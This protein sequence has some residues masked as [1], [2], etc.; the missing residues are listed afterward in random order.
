MD[1][2]ECN[3]YLCKTGAEIIF[4]ATA[5]FSSHQKDARKSNMESCNICCGVS[6]FNVGRYCCPPPEAGKARSELMSRP[7]GLGVSG[8]RNGVVP[9]QHSFSLIWFFS[10]CLGLQQQQ[11][12]QQQQR[13]RQRQQQQQQPK[14]KPR[15][16]QRRP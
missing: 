3:Y 16:G 13:R 10:S 7:M 12:Q 15:P 8:S 14:K 9:S 2:R 6:A 1:C 4:F 11:Q 5:C